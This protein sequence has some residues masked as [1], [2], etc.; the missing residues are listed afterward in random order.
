MSA[1]DDL[2]NAVSGRFPGAATLRA[3]VLATLLASDDMSDLQ[4]V[5]EHGTTR[6][7]IVMRA[8]SRRYHWP[9]ER[10]EFATNL[11]DGRVA[12]A[13]L[14]TLP[15]AVIADAAAAGAGEWVARVKAA[16]A[17]RR[18]KAMRSASAAMD[19]Q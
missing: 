11:P 14:Y 10:R 1:G 7:A 6:L 3:E 13:S 18:R 8:L 19:A 5:F 15:A 12:W 17:E 9:V 16:R 4:S 2:A